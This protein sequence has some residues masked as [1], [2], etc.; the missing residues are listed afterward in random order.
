MMM[1]DHHL[2][3]LSLEAK[4]SAAPSNASMGSDGYGRHPSPPGDKH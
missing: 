1:T 4:R 2:V 3:I